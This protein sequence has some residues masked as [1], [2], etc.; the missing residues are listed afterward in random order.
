MK[1]SQMK[2]PQ[3]KRSVEEITDE[4]ITDEEIT[5]EES[6]KLQEKNTLAFSNWTLQ[7]KSLMKS[8]HAK[9]FQKLVR[10]NSYLGPRFQCNVPSHR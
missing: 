4:E 3:M 7:I 10:Y 6:Q 2:R 8:A 5:D 1:R 9:H